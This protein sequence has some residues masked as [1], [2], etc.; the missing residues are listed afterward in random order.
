LQTAGALLA[1]S[2]ALL[3]DCVSMFLDTL[4]YAGNLFAEMRPAQNLRKSV[5]LNLFFYLKFILFINCCKSKTPFFKLI[6]SRIFFYLFCFDFSIFH[7]NARKTFLTQNV[8]DFALDRRERDH[9]IA[10][11]ISFL[12]LLGITVSFFIEGL[13]LATQPDDEDDDDVNPYIV[14]LFNFYIFCVHRMSVF[15]FEVCLN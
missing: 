5:F 7:N 8:C 13:Q 9:L 4:T 10:S 12:A 14:S 11:G 3:S 2:L 15:Q 1:H 6:N